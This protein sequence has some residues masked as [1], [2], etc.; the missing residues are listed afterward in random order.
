MFEAIT[1]KTTLHEKLSIN[2]ECQD[3][4]SNPSKDRNLDIGGDQK[5][6][7]QSTKNEDGS[8]SR[9]LRS[10]GRIRAILD[11]KPWPFSC[12]SY[13]KVVEMGKQLARRHFIHH[14]FE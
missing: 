2:Q 7:R 1:I 10:L 5:R 6:K 9:R 4:R 3:I 13:C 12:P 11:A 14:I 8:C